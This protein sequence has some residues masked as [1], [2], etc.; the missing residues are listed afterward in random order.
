MDTNAR[1]KDVME[2]LATDG[3]CEVRGFGT[4]EAATLPAGEARNPKTGETVAVGER[5]TI[6][7]RPSKRARLRI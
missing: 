2:R 5:K 3:K 7:F 1:L 4:F 6:R